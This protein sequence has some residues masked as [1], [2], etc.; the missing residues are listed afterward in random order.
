MVV[1]S[2]PLHTGATGAVY[3]GASTAALVVALFADTATSVATSGAI[4]LTL[5]GF[6]GAFAFRTGASP[7]SVEAAPLRDAFS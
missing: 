6:A 1:G 2:G 7:P 4:T 3:V 5:F